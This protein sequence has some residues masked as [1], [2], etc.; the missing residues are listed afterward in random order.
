MAGSG[1]IKVSLWMTDFELETQEV[2]V[3]WEDIY[4]SRQIYSTLLPELQK[5]HY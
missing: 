5:H 2:C 4:C 3:Q 1:L